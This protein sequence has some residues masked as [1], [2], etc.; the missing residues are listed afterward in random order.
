MIVEKTFFR[1]CPS[2]FPKLSS[3]QRVPVAFIADLI[4]SQEKVVLR[5][6]SFF[7]NTKPFLCFSK[8][9]EKWIFFCVS[10][11]RKVV[12]EAYAHPLRYFSALRN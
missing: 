9:Q 6:E 1:L 4:S 3:G 7:G 5:A 12:S 11:W 2:F 8:F 10:S